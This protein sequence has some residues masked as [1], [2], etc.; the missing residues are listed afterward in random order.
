MCIRDSSP[1][2]SAKIHDFIDD[3]G[4]FLSNIYKLKKLNEMKRIVYFI[5]VLFCLFV[6]S[7][8]VNAQLIIRNMKLLG[9]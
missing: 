3:F 2:I 1:T 8:Q 4:H 6:T 7:T 5:A 9:L